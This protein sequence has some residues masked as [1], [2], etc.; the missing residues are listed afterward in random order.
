MTFEAHTTTVF[1]SK[2]RP[3]HRRLLTAFIIVAPPVLPAQQSLDHAMTTNQFYARHDSAAAAARKAG[4]WATY[5]THILILDSLLNGH[6]NVRVAKA[7]IDAHLGDTADAY[8]NLRDFAEMGLTRKLDADTTLAALHGTDQW[9]VIM[10]R[11]AGNGATVGNPLKAFAMP[12]SEMIAEDIS[13]DPRGRRFLITSVRKGRIFS[14]MP[15]GAVTTFAEPVGAGWGMMAVAVD[16]TRHVLWATAEA[17]PQA[18]GY[19]DAAQGK[20]AV[21]KYDLSSG[22]LL[23]RYDL[24]AAE[25]HQA[26]DIALVPNGDLIVSDGDTGS[27]YI[28]RSGRGL[29]L[30]VQPGEFRSPQGPAVSTD[31]RYF[32]VADYTRGLARVDLSNGGVMWLA[33]P[34]NVALNG[35]DGLSLVDRRTL[36]GVQNGTAPNRLLMIS[37][38]PSGTHVVSAKVAVQSAELLHDPTH[39]AFV[40]RDYYFIA[41]GGFGAFGEDGKPVAGEKVVAPTILRVVNMK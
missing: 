11:I 16:S 29:E 23:Q 12:D 24:P 4:D 41:N 1:S 6:P 26:G 8:R 22:K 36:L 5:K 37:L 19:T 10:A 21:L 28:I 20:S 32:Y 40:G 27:I 39:G 9:N 2:M 14:V 35:I 34:P 17:V 33:H 18:I 13:Y 15:S 31:S 7:R 25:K 30:L 38:D 3:A